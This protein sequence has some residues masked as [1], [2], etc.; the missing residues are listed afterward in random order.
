[1]SLNTEGLA[2]V[3]VGVPTKRF[4]QRHSQK[5]SAKISSATIFRQKN[6]RQNI[7]GKISSAKNSAAK[8]SSAKNSSAKESS[9]KA[10]WAK[11]IQ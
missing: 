6:L 10:S 7:F 3:P 2:E 8:N 1:M 5:P 4:R 11:R 9:A